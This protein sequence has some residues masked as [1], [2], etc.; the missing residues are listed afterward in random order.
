MWIDPAWQPARCATVGAARQSAVV[1]FFYAL[2]AS[3]L[4][5][6]DDPGILPLAGGA[7]MLRLR[8]RSFRPTLTA[9]TPV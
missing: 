4:R 5:K 2:R 6:S 3:V 8:F 1:K 7:T 9:M